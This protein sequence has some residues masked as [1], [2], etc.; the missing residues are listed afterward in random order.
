MRKTWIS[1]VVLSAS[2]VVAASDQKPQWTSRQKAAFFKIHQSLSPQSRADL[3]RTV[4]RFAQ[5]FGPNNSQNDPRVIAL[6]VA[7][8]MAIEGMDVIA[9]AFYV[10]GAASRSAEDDLGSLMDE[11]QEMNRAK[12]KLR[13]QIQELR[14]LIQN[15]ESAGQRGPKVR[16]FQAA[17][18]QPPQPATMELCRPA[19][20]RNFRIRYCLALKIEAL[21][22]MTN[23]TTAQL[24]D[25]L[26][27]LQRQLKQFGNLIQYN[28]II[29]DDAMAGQARI[30][31]IMSNFL[32]VQNDVWNSSIRN[33]K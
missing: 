18:G 28:Q 19:W 33:M 15:S 11:M 24:R 13:N 21:P 32:K 5:C 16:V 9:L 20:T 31:N 30:M 27:L 10:L 4:N 23:W 25:R 22:D 6:Q 2:L 8:G 3:A 17:P 7:E 29:L 26:D 12:Q 1:V 14:Q